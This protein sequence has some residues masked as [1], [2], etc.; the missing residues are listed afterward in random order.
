MRSPVL[1]RPLRT[2]IQSIF[3]PITPQRRKGKTE[4][5]QAQQS[6]MEAKRTGCDG[7]AAAEAHPANNR[8][9]S[10][11]PPRYKARQRC[12]PSNN[13]NDDDDSAAD[14]RPSGSR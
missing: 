5:A 13:N 10:T 8:R 14:Q 3:I 11:P 1:K 2:C 4:T 6:A 7:A 12:N 9:A